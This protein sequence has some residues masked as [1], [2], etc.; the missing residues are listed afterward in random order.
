MPPVLESSNMS[1]GAHSAAGYGHEVII[2][3]IGKALVR[4][5]AFYHMTIIQVA[6]LLALCQA[7]I[8]C[9][10]YF[11]KKYVSSMA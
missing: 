8:L 9:R 2:S 6:L 5:K 7:M 1:A 11:F 10:I 4:D 3:V